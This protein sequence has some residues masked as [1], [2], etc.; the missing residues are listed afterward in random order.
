[1]PRFSLSLCHEYAGGARVEAS[2]STE[3]PVVALAGP[4]GSGKSTVL[5]V[6]AG[7]IRPFSGH[8]LLADPASALFDL[9]TGFW[10]RPEFRGIGYL[11]QQPLLFPHLTVEQNLRYG[12]GRGTHRPALDF[13]NLVARL[14]LTALLRRRPGQLSGG[15]GQR[16]A[17]GRALLSRPDLLLLDEPFAAL[18]AALRKELLAELSRLLVEQRW[19]VV[20]VSHQEQELSQLA[21]AGLGVHVVRMAEG[22]VVG[23]EDL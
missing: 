4:S 22:T 5:K 14:G 6:L 13:S 21:E 11:P 10:P 9:R 15:E 12:E 2:W 18:D 1:M 20:Y 17:L 23:C 3:A 7:M 19:P 8:A 16:A